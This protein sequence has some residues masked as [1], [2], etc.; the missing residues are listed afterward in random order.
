MPGPKNFSY[1]NSL[2]Y[3]FADETKDPLKLQNL[4]ISC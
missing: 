4:L 2:F 1:I 3:S